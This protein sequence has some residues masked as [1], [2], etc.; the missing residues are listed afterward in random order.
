MPFYTKR[1]A[2]SQR[3]FV[4]VVFAKFCDDVGFDKR[5][6]VAFGVIINTTANLLT[7]LKMSGTFTTCSD[8]DTIFIKQMEDSMVSQMVVVDGYM[9]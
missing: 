4:V 5:G 9:S 6:A 1:K 8:L 2:F 3:C 7:L